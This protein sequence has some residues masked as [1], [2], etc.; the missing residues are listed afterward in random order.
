MSKIFNSFA[1]AN[2]YAKNV[3]L[4]GHHLVK[5]TRIERDK[6]QVTFSNKQ[7]IETNKEVIES[8]KCISCDNEIPQARLH[9]DPS[10]KYCV[11]CL[12]DLEVKDPKIYLR[13][14]DVDGIGGSREHAKRTLRNR[15][16]E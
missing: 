11:I 7:I 6:F 12:N 13:N 16:Y 4:E 8:F 2:E 15:K 5:C 9:I 3:A 1:E 10:A 14:T